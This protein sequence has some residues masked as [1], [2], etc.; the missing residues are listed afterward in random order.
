MR[1]PT[2]TNAEIREAFKVDGLSTTNVADNEWVEMQECVA[3]L[4]MTALDASRP[5]DT[6]WTS[7]EELSDA[8]YARADRIV[9]V[10][11]FRGHV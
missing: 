4:I 10:I 7:A 1:L 3:H 9:E 6:T 11:D 8:V 2:P 5:T